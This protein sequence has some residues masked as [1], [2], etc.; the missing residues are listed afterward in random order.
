MALSLHFIVHLD[1]K[2]HASFV[3]TMGDVRSWLDRCQI[4]SASF[5]PVTSAESG[6]GFDIGFKSEDEALRFER[7]FGQR[8]S[9]DG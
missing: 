3:E 2:P 4:E 6:V 7:A 5:K 1:K 8:S 9:T